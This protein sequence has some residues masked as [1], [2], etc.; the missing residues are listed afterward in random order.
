MSSPGFRSQRRTPR[1]RTPTP[2]GWFSANWWVE[3]VYAGELFGI[4]SP[5]VAARERLRGRCQRVLA[6]EGPVHRAFIVRDSDIAGAIAWYSVIA[7]T[8]RE[9]VVLNSSFWWNYW[10]RRVRVRLPRRPLLCDLSGWLW[11]WLLVDRRTYYVHRRW[12]DE[13]R[14]ANGEMYGG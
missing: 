10:P 14:A 12:F 11:G 5:S 3:F 7:L 4:L 9:V 1:A 8:D 2:A 13:V 6:G